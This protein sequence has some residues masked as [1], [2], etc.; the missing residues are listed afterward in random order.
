MTSD[1]DPGRAADPPPAPISARRAYAESLIVFA[2]VFASGIVSAGETLGGARQAHTGSWAQY[3]PT[4]VQSVCNMALICLVVILLS[5]R[6]GV[7]SRRLGVCLPRVPEGRPNAGRAAPGRGIRM[8]ALAFLALAAGGAVT[9]AVSMGNHLP[10]PAH[11]SVPF[12]VV[13]LFSG[14]L[15]SGVVEEMVALAFVV[16]TLKQANRPVAEIAIVA[17][18]LRCTYHIYYGPGVLGIVIW[19]AA[20][21]FLYLRFR[22]VIPLIVIHVCWDAVQYLTLAWHWFAVVSVAAALIFLLAAL[23]LWLVDLASHHSKPPY[24]GMPPYG[25]APGYGPVPPYPYLQPPQR[26]QEPRQGQENPPDITPPS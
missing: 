18:L 11:P 10:L 9:A 22:S 20:F 12:V 7:T 17:V 8:A 24:G 25:T 15:F 6:R 13:S 14:A 2:L 19:A 4:I 3:A 23:V 1:A 16:S 26:P 5:A 21:V